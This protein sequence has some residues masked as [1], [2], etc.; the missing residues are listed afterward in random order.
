MESYR[1]MR[2]NMGSYDPVNPSW[3]LCAAWSKSMVDQDPHVDFEIWWFF[4]LLLYEYEE[5]D[6]WCYKEFGE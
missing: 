1:V 3:I 2:S 6:D 4:F 5:V